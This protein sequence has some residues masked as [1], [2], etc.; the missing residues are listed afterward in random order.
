M[1]ALPYALLALAVLAL[2]YRFYSRFLSEKI[3]QL[4]PDE[5]MPSTTHEDGVD[6]VP[7]KREVLWGHHFD[8]DLGKARMAIRVLAK[9]WSLGASKTDLQRIK[10]SGALGVKCGV[11]VR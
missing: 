8:G 9:L 4:R 10:N 11:L 6:F 5:V 7:T 3:F 2:G 1:L